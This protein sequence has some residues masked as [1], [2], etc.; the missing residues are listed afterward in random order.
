MNQVIFT[1]DCPEPRFNFTVLGAYVLELHKLE[2]R[3]EVLREEAARA[4]KYSS[5]WCVLEEDI[6]EVM[7]RISVI[8][9]RLNVLN[10]LGEGKE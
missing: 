3:L 10:A 1:S 7:F 9:K 4:P 6:T 8:R 5:L 2:T